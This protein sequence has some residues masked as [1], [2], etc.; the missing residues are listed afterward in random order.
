MQHPF[1][2]FDR[3]Y[4]SLYIEVY[5]IYEYYFLFDSDI[6]YTTNHMTKLTNHI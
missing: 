4:V 3:N 1:N 5:I 6:D 2:Y